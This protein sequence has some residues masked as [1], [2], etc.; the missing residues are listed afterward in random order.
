[1]YTKSQLSK[2][3]GSAF[4]LQFV[5]SFSSGVLLRPLWYNA[6]DLEGTFNHISANPGLIYG[7]ILLDL[8]TTFGVTFLGVA[9]Y[10]ALKKHNATMAMTGMA[11]YILEGAFITVSQ[12][13]TFSLVPISQG[14]TA[15]NQMII[16]AGISFKMLDYVG[17]A[18]HMLAF[19]SGA[20]ILYSLLYR[21]KIVPAAFS[22]WGLISMLPLCVGTLT[23]F[24]DT[25]IPFYLYAPYIPFE[26]AIGTWIL[27]KGLRE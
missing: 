14:I 3:L 25:H 23:G 21:S 27:I 19:C 5:T 7:N 12:V 2:I 17:S 26:L 1:M 16:L 13:I 6:D 20:I 24:F 15:G 4:L 22:L 8:I 10:Q 9:L 18:F 11:F